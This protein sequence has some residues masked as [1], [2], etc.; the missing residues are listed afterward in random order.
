MFFS[1]DLVD[2][3]PLTRDLGLPKAWSASTFQDT[4]VIFSGTGVVSLP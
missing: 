2:F 1:P 4:S 3:V